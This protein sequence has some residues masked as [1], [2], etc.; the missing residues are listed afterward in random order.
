MAL[1][2]SAATHAGP[3]QTRGIKPVSPTLQGP[4]SQSVDHQKPPLCHFSV[5]F[6]EA[7]VSFSCPFPCYRI[8]W[9]PRGLTWKNMLTENLGACEREYSCC[10]VS[11]VVPYAPTDGGVFQG[12]LCLWSSGPTCPLA[13]LMLWLSHV[14][15]CNLCPPWQRQ[16][17]RSLYFE[18][19]F[20]CWVWVDMTCSRIFLIQG[21]GRS[22]AGE[23]LAPPLVSIDI[24][25]L[26]VRVF[27]GLSLSASSDSAKAYLLSK[28]HLVLCEVWTFVTN[29]GC[30]KIS[31]WFFLPN[32]NYYQ[33]L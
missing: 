3:S 29:G 23:V 8:T 20:S 25:G 9:P 22:T 19:S 2:G 10:L 13:A 12:H 33:R 14:H 21:R 28:G 1:C 7:H 32:I 15:S 11:L 31:E 24:L 17:E 16:T 5:S 18:I 27:A 30:R 4:N 6:S 26:V